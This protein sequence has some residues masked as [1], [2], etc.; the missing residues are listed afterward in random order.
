MDS[1]CAVGSIWETTV[2][3]DRAGTLERDGDRHPFSGRPWLSSYAPGVAAEI[4]IPQESLSEMFAATAA[5]FGSRVALDFYGSETT[6]EDLATQVRRAAGALRDAGVE[7]GDRVALVLPNCPQHVVAFYAV[8]RLGA[9]V[10]EHNPLY[11]PSELE[12]QLSD[13][14]AAVVVCWD[15]TARVI[16]KLRGQTGVQTIL[17]V[18]VTT[19]LPWMQ[20]VA[21]LLPVRKARSARAAMTGP[22]PEDVRSW[23]QAVLSSRPLDPD[24]PQPRPQDTALL[25]Y[26]GGTTGVPK[27]A[28]LT[29]RN[30]RANAAQGRAWMP[31]MVDGEETVFAVLPLFHAY[32]LTMCLTFSMSIGATLVLFPRFDLDQVLEAIKRRPPTFLPAV[33]PIYERLST[34]ARERHVDLSSIRYAISGAMALPPAVVAMW[35]SVS[36]GLLVEG[37]GMTETSPISLANPAA[38]TRRPG[39]VGVPFP[40]TLIRIVDP[41]DPTQDLLLGQEG[42]LLISGPQVFAGYWNCP[43]E[44]EA[45]LLPGGWLRTGDV[46]VADSDG[47]IR[48]VDRLKE[49]IITGGFNVYPSEIEEV[50]RDFPD[51][52]DLAVVGVRA[53]RDTGEEVVVAIVPVDGATIDPELVK[54]YSRERLT[55][56]KVP[57]RVVIM[58]DLPRSQIGKILRRKIRDKIEA[59]DALDAD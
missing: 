58:E 42:E 7:R 37:Y 33:P 26:T 32:G 2:G 20:R 50:L 55:G 18:D 31:G 57:R 59:A 17:A 22:V 24:H 8:L 56:Y 51:I 54:A 53:S 12:H 45:V 19:A 6:Y 47:F 15:R 38:P 44:T 41:Q 16:D 3:T 35:E 5:R 49:L 21:L 29:H 4:E 40:S 1:R 48:I 30:L 14:G 13:C 27:G 52:A 36:G 39:T 9:V 25:Q 11:K 43:E 46:A 34:V 10:V 28:I 23:D